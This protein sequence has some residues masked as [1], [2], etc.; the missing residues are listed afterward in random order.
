MSQ[1]TNLTMME[2]SQ[3]EPFAII[4]A[5]FKMRERI[6]TQEMYNEDIQALSK[7]ID[8]NLLNTPKRKD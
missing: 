4:E 5:G 1:H 2:D 3:A 8:P 6:Y 7:T